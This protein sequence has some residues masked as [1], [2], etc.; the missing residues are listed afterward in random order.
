MN[1]PWRNDSGTGKTHLLTALCVAACRQKRRVR[2]TTAANLVNELVEAQQ[3][4]QLRRA[5]ARWA[6]YDVLALDEV[7]YVPLA[8]LGAEFLFQVI[9]ERAEQAAVILTTN[10]PFSEWTQVIP[11]ARLCK[12]L[13]DRITDRAHIVETGTESFRFRRTLGARGR[14]EG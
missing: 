6:R 7:G 10:L 9:A 12:A 4:G 13:L 3:Q 8:E 14:Q 2:F 11:N 5:L 1:T